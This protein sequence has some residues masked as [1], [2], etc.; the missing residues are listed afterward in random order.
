[1]NRKELDERLKIIEAE[2]SKIPT[3]I[4]TSD[5]TIENLAM[6]DIRKE[7]RDIRNIVGEIRCGGSHSFIPQN[8]YIINNRITGYRKWCSVCGKTEEISEKEYY[9]LCVEQIDKRT[10]EAKQNGAGDGC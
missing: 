9:Q 1:M 6:S 8:Q 3:V 10:T 2:I 7:L 4:R 5:R